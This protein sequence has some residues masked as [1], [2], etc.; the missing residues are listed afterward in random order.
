MWHYNH[1]ILLIFFIG[2]LVYISW[3]LLF[4]KKRRKLDFIRFQQSSFEKSNI[5][6]LITGMQE[7]KLNNCEQQKRRDWEKIQSK[8]NY[9]K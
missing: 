2:S 8:L 3:I 5:I 9:I 4:L 1:T 6:Q 7:I